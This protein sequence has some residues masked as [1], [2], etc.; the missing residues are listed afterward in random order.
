MA[1]GGA[2]R[3]PIPLRVGDAAWQAVGVVVGPA[4]A[5]ATGATTGVTDGD[6]VN[7][8]SVPRNLSLSLVFECMFELLAVLPGGR[9]LSVVC[10]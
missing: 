9:A 8:E 6:D 7:T 3:V 10:P 5:V 1:G 2:V 4:A